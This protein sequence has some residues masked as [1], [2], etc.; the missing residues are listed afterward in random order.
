MG[1]QDLPGNGGILITD[2]S[3]EDF[4]I[5]MEMNNDFDQDSGLFL[6]STEDSK[7]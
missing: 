2:E 7:A 4:E 1:S 6:R 5:V 3:F